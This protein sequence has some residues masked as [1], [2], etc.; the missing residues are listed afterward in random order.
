MYAIRSYYALE[1]FLSE[2]P[3][4]FALTVCTAPEGRIETLGLFIGNTRKVLEDAVALSQ[5]KNIDFVD[6]GIK[7]CIVYLDP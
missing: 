5:E 3:V 2:K 4:W 7:K 1:K 6:H